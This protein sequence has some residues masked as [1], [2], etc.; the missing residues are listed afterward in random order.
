MG[1]YVLTGGATGIGAAIK[2]QLLDQGNDICCHRP[3]R[4]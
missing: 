4:R 3:E 2:Q 1:K